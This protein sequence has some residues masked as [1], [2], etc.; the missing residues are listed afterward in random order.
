M[1][2]FPSWR[3]SV[4]GLEPVGHQVMEAVSLLAQPP[5][6]LE[7]VRLLR[8]Q[9]LECGKSWSSLIGQTRVRYEEIRN[10]AEE[11]MR[12]CRLFIAFHMK[13]R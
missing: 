1:R 3:A 12:Y 10:M 7:C 9:I 13:I 4:S 5:E 8:R 6:K 2:A 11:P